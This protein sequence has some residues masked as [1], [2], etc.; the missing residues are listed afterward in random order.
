M[1]KQT[2]RTMLLVLPLVAVSASAFAGATI[3][4]RRYWPN[5]ARRGAQGMSN[6]QGDWSSAFGSVPATPGHYFAPPVDSSRRVWRY[7]GGPKSPMIQN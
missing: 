7:Q 6:P 4:D 5:E 1:F 2:F 3:S